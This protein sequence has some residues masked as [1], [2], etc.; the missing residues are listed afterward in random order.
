MSNLVESEDLS[1]RLTEKSKNSK[2]PFDTLRLGHGFRIPE[3]VKL[4]V[5]RTL[6]SRWHKDNENSGKRF[7]VYSDDKTVVRMK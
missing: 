4:S 3:D 2:Y 5:M 6:V 1:F 7:R